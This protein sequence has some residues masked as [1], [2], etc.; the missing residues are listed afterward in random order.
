MRSSK[1][2][3][4]PHMVTMAS[5][6]SRS[7]R[8][9]PKTEHMSGLSRVLVRA[10][11]RIVSGARDENGIGRLACPEVPGY[12]VLHLS[13]VVR[14]AP[15]DTVTSAREAAFLTSCRPAARSCRLSAVSI[16]RNGLM[17]A[18]ADA[19]ENSAE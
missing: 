13:P 18:S 16:S 3:V 1:H 15:F 6:N 11:A 19:I 12:L 10:L 5:T 9:P 4:P 8:V 17:D 2:M 14:Y 7:S